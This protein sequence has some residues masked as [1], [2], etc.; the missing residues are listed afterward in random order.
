VAEVSITFTADIETIRVF[1]NVLELAAKHQSI[2]RD[3]DDYYWITGLVE[4][5][6]ELAEE[7]LG[8]HEHPPEVELRQIASICMNW[9]VKI[10]EAQGD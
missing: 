5:V 4:E 10:E 6:G 7:S 2:W 9:P 8:N 1:S 3:K